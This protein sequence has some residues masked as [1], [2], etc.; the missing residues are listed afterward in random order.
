MKEYSITN[1]ILTA[2]I[3]EKGA[4]LRSVIYKEKEYMWQGGKLWPRT[5][6]VCCPWCG[7]VDG[8]KFEHEGI[9]YAAPRHGFVRDAVHRLTEKKVDSLCF[10]FS[11]DSGDKRWPWPFGLSACYELSNN[12]LKLTYKIINTGTQV[13]PL[14]FGFHP[15][16]IAPKGSTI[17]AEEGELLSGVKTLPIISGTFDNDRICLKQPKSTWFALERAD[18]RRVTIDTQGYDY[19]LLWGV[20]GN[21]PFVCIEPWTAYPGPG[22]MYERP[23]VRKLEPTEEFNCTLKLTFA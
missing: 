12:T 6:P 1:N 22:G 11:L 10:V 8:D 13:M 21:T 19:V 5:A 23:S 3:N 9:S 7:V 14:Q 18:G 4:E 2:R 20:P 17:H 16:F 15:G